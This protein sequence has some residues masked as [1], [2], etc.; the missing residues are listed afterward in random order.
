MEEENRGEESSNSVEGMDEKGKG[1]GE[2]R[3]ESVVG[4]FGEFSLARVEQIYKRGEGL[5]R[6]G[7]Q[8]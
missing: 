6:M 3:V 5:R 2:E 8:D 1:R 7:G 4:S